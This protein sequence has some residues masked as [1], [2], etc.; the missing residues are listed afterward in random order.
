M[1]RQSFVDAHCQ[2]ESSFENVTSVV[3]TLNTRRSTDELK[4]L[5]PDVYAGSI[6]VHFQL[7]LFCHQSL[8]QRVSLKNVL[9]TW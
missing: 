3:L 7:P 6:F 4:S 9:H 2:F 5:K 1:K 8:Y